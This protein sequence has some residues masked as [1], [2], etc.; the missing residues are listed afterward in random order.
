MRRQ[1]LSSWRHMYRPVRPSAIAD[2]RAAAGRRIMR[3]V[4]E[5]SMTGIAIEPGPRNLIIDDEGIG[6][7]NAED[8]R[9]WSG[10]TVVLPDAPAVAAVDVR[11]GGPGSRETE[12][13]GAAA[14]VQEVHAVVLSGGSAFGLDAGSAAASWLAARGVGFAI[15][16]THVP[17]V[18]A[19]IL[20]DLANGGDKGW[21]ETPPY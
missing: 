5:G 15:A 1:R 3:P 14:L 6:V 7:G 12:A 10:V 4:E 17:I 18:P 19:A 9:A 20:F 13:L 21:G 16:G 2:C 8:G 11:G